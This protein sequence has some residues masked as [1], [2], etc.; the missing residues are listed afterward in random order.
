[1]YQLEIR[2]C[3]IIDPLILAKD[4]ADKGINSQDIQVFWWF[5]SMLLGISWADSVNSWPVPLDKSKFPCNYWQVMK[6]MPI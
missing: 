6:I 5:S 1:M 2:A 4:S 3:S